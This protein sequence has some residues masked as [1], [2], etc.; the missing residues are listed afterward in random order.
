LGDGLQS[1]RF[2]LCK[3][4]WFILHLFSIACNNAVCASPTG[5]GTR[6]H[7]WAQ[8][9]LL[10]FGIWPFLNAIVKIPS[11]EPP[12]GAVDTDAQ[13]RAISGS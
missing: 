13:S 10:T 1:E 11:V 3:R 6:L 5:S 12:I 4:S 9:Q 7:I 2:N 8:Q